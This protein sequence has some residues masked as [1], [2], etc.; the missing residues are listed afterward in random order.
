MNPIQIC[1]Y[2]QVKP[3]FP[4][5]IAEFKYVNSPLGTIGMLPTKLSTASFPP[6]NIVLICVAK[7]RYIHVYMCACE[8]VCEK[9]I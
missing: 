3:N 8:C 6:S 4:Y 5:K 9:M 2:L 1:Y 7:H